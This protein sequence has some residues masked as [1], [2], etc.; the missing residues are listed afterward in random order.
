MITDR[1]R[2]KIRTGRV[3]SD[4]RDKTITVTVQRTYRHSLYGRVVKTNKKFMVHDK[5]NDAHIGDLVEIMETRPLSK[6]KR[7]RLTKLLERAK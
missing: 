6:T 4:A 2:R 5:N 7:W 3:T 1:G